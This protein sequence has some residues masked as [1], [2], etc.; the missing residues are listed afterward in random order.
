MNFPRLPYFFMN[1]DL[2]LAVILER[3]VKFISAVLNHQTKT[4]RAHA[5]PSD[6]R[7][8]SS[9]YFSLQAT[10]IDAL[11]SHPKLGFSCCGVER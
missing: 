4:S 5:R 10:R 2:C 9:S 11:F 7:D 6:L 1:R 3:D 8:S